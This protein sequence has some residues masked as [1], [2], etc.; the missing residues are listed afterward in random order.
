MKAIKEY[1]EGCI[2]G[3]GTAYTQRGRKIKN[4]EYQILNDE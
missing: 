4:I 1:Y 3:V 2:N